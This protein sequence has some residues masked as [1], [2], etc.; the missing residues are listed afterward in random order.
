MGDLQDGWLAFESA[1]SRRRLAP[2]PARWISVSLEE[3]EELCR[4]AQPVIRRKTSPS[5]EH[6]AL[7]AE[8]VET[9]AMH[10]DDPT[11][12]FTTAR[13]RLWAVRPLER[14]RITGGGTETVLRFSSEDTEVDLAGFPDNWRRASVAEFALMV[15]DA[16]PPTLRAGSPQRRISDRE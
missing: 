4:C 15:L 2:Y 6:Q 3:L 12:T 14:V 9:A 1:D 11:V 16:R 10:E 13:G 7:V 5:G 8:A